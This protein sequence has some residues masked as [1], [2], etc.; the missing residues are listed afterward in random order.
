M[1]EA[2]PADD[3]AAKLM[4]GLRPTRVV[5]ADPGPHWAE[6]F[7]EHAARLRGVLGGRARLIEHIGSTSVPGLA[8][9]PIVDIVVGI[10]DPDD[11]AA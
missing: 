2:S 4:H 6:R 11:E 3:L 8:A 5:L 7:V 1:P 10:D 9:K